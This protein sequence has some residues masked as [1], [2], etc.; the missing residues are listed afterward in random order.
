MLLAFCG[1]LDRASSVYDGMDDEFLLDERPVFPDDN[2]LSA[3]A[4]PI[5]SVGSS[6]LVS[7]VV[8]SYLNG[9]RGMAGVS[10]GY[11][12][13][14]AE[15][16]TAGSLPV[17]IGQTSGLG[18][19]PSGLFS[20]I[21]QNSNPVTAA[22]YPAGVSGSFTAQPATQFR[23]AQSQFPSSTTQSKPLTPSGVGAPRISGRSDFD[24]NRKIAQLLH[25][26]QK[27]LMAQEKRLEREASLFEDVVPEQEALAHKNDDL[28]RLR[29]RQK[30]LGTHS[31]HFSTEDIERD[32]LRDRVKAQKSALE[33]ASNKAAEVALM[34]DPIHAKYLQT[35]ADLDPKTISTDQMRLLQ[36]QNVN[37]LNKLTEATGQ[38][39]GDAA[40][41]LTECAN[42]G[43]DVIKSKSVSLIEPPPPPPDDP[44]DEPLTELKV[45]FSRHL[46]GLYILMHPLLLDFF[47]MTSSTR[48]FE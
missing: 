46:V 42:C 20:L 23:F 1:R 29:A 33:E 45:H 8:H 15:S 26:K 19:Y 39:V 40:K 21:Q 38:N 24:Q 5:P 30:W 3:A 10:A 13:P 18:S 28:M 6:G 37:L 22:A 16:V 32:Q 31:K 2:P 17:G 41:T 9:F 27:R 25:R 36:R 14:V 11:A 7:P 4:A 48:L 43:E 12:S 34:V 35:G 47:R 44:L